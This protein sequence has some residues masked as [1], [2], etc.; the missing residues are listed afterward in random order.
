MYTSRRARQDKPTIRIAYRTVAESCAR[1]AAVTQVLR[2]A[3][4][5]GVQL[6][7]DDIDG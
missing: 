3:Q 4:D 1:A 7:D 6:S 5:A 2:E